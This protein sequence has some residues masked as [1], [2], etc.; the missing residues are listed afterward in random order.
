MWFRGL[1]VAGGC[2]TLTSANSNIRRL[3]LGNEE[4][5]A[6]CFECRL[7]VA[8]V[9]SVCVCVDTP[10]GDESSFVKKDE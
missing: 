4:R 8:R 10:L 7:R 9:S 3:V 1:E 5:S 2:V 6:V